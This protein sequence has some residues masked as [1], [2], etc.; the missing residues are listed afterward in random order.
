[1][2]PSLLNGHFCH[3]S[4]LW[5]PPAEVFTVSLFSLSSDKKL[6]HVVLR[7]LSEPL[8]GGGGEFVPPRWKMP[9]WPTYNFV[10]SSSPSP[11]PRGCTRGYIRSRP[12]RSRQEDDSLTLSSERTS[13]PHVDPHVIQSDPASATL[14]LTDGGDELEVSRYCWLVSRCIPDP[15]PRTLWSWSLNE[16]RCW[17]R[18]RPKPTPPPHLHTSGQSIK[19]KVS[20]TPSSRSNQNAQISFSDVHRDQTQWMCSAEIIFKVTISMSFFLA[21]LVVIRCNCRCVFPRSELCCR[22]EFTLV[23]EVSSSVVMDL[24]SVQP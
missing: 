22:C 1:M 5:V 24:S 15:S 8:R 2:L 10:Q 12:Q 16:S 4:R 3:C 13:P 21:A 6:F 20:R 17:E 11:P 18:E 9:F 7:L 14:C 23:F 19:H